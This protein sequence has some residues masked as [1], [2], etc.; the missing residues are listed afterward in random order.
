MT[1]LTM[2]T[3]SVGYVQVLKINPQSQ[4]LSQMTKKTA[5]QCLSVKN[6]LIKPL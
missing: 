1:T 2:L 4:S 5:S 6:G 3:V